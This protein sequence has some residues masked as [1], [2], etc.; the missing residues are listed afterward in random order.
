M[1]IVLIRHPQ[2]ERNVDEK[3]ASLTPEGRK[4]AEQLA[5]SLPKLS[6]GSWSLASPFTIVV[7]SS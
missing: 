5:A 3:I 7:S 1:D 2:R 6:A 4:T